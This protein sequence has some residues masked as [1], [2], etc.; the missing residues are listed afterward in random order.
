MLED[1]KFVEPGGVGQATYL[2]EVRMA[3]FLTAL[4]NHNIMHEDWTLT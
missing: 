4:R 2:Y 3:A 1:S